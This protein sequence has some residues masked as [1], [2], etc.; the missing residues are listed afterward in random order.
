MAVSWTSVVAHHG[1]DAPK[2]ATLVTCPWCASFYVAI[3]VVVARRIAPR[4][5]TPIARALAGSHL[6]GLAANIDVD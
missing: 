2:L 3:A 1:D 4:A 5:W 6:A